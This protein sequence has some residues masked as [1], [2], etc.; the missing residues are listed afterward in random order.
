VTDQ[1][2]RLRKVEE[3]RQA[4]DFALTDDAMKVVV[5]SLRDDEN[6]MAVQIINS[7]TS[8][9]TQM[10]QIASLHTGHLASPDEIRRAN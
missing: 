6:Y 4:L 10:L 7:T 1:E 5:V 3:A 2:E 9:A 8:Q